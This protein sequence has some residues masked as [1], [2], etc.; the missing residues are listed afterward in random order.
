M[1][2][3]RQLCVAKDFYQY[4]FSAVLQ[5]NAAILSILG[6]FAIFKIQNLQASSANIRNFLISEGG[7]F[8]QLGA[9]IEFDIKSTVDKKKYL[10]SS[11]NLNSSRVQL[12]R[13]WIRNDEQ[14]RNISKSIKLP[15]FLLIIGII[16]P[17]FYLV[18][19]D[20]LYIYSNINIICFV[21]PF[22][23]LA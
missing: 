5:A 7:R 10:E 21:A 14:I 16:L 15:I 6:L 23:L 1:Q 22:L 11:N 3:L 12:L 4:F 13:E 2:L 9:I 17:M 8:L 19:G 18:L 20:Y